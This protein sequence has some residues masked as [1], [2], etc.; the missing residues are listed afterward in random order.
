MNNWNHVSF[1]RIFTSIAL[2][3]VLIVLFL[4]SI[5]ISNW[6]AYQEA[7]HTNARAMS[8]IDYFNMQF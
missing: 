5:Y 2:G 7:I 3:L 1:Y 6:H 8:N 4:I